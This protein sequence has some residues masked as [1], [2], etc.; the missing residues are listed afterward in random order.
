[1]LQKNDSGYRPL[2][3]NSDSILQVLK[4]KNLQLNTAQTAMVIGT[5]DFV[6][7]V[8]S[9]IA[10]SG[11]S[12]IIVSLFEKKRSVEFEK[13]IK[14]FIFNL[15]IKIVQ[16][17]DLTRIQTPSG[18]LISNLTESM[19]KE[20]FESLAYFNFLSRGAVFVDFQSYENAGLIEEAKRA[21]L[22]VVEEL[23]I[24]TLKYNSL[25]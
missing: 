12:N 3:L 25:I 2:N 9:K 17:I 6:L 19:N 1:M 20:A 24:L 7:S 11:Y 23:E 18:L 14:E 16:L 4:N 8:T 22:N 5:Y 13:K 15:N 10:L 21:E